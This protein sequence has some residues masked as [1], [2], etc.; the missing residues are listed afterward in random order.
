[1]TQLIS[2][3][4]RK[5]AAYYHPD[6]STEHLEMA[7]RIQRAI[8]EATAKLEQENKELKA[9]VDKRYEELLHKRF[10][11]QPHPDDAKKCNCAYC[12]RDFEAIAEHAANL[13]MNEHSLEQRVKQLESGCD[14]EQCGVCVKCAESERDALKKRLA[15]V[16]ADKSELITRLNLRRSELR[17]I[18][19][20]YSE[21]VRAGNYQPIWEAI[22]AVAALNP[23]TEPTE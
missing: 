23:P 9:V 17:E 21:H 4:A 5:C 6:Q 22:E 7:V 14:N 18:T 2:D 12:A 19:Y 16:E 20:Q 13:E 10:F 3:E 1:M 15:E 11:F 8:N